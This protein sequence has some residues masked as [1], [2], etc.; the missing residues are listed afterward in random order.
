MVRYPKYGFLTIWLTKMHPGL[1]H[2]C[3][4]IKPTA[5]RKSQKNFELQASLESNQKAS[6]VDFP[7]WKKPGPVYLR[8]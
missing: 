6:G 3:L 5:V 7:E 2:F 1:L 8:P 4:L